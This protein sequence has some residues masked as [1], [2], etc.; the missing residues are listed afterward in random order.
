MGYASAL[1]IPKVLA[2]PRLTAQQ[3]DVIELIEAFA[4]QAVAVIRA[5]ELDPAVVNPMGGEIPELSGY[6]K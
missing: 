1:A 2:K 6:R 3:L 4:A 5:A